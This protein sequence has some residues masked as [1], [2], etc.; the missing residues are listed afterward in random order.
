MPTL[1]SV[2]STVMATTSLVLLTLGSGMA[3]AAPIDLG[4]DVTWTGRTSSFALNKHKTFQ[5]CVRF[6]CSAPRA[7]TDARNSGSSLKILVD[8]IDSEVAGPSTL[9]LN[10]G[11]S[12]LNQILLPGTF[13]PLTLTYGFGFGTEIR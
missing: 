3:F 13:T 9:V 5:N 11:D 7:C 4:N 1:P 6:L 2:R 8:F 12:L 10:V